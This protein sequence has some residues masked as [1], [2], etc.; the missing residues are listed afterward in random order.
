M[1]IERRQIGAVIETGPADWQIIQ[2]D[3][4]GQA[5]IS[6]AGSWVGDTPGNVEVRLLREES[7]APVAEDLDWQA[8]DRTLGDGSWRT[9]LRGVPAGG[10]YR[11]ETRYRPVK[12]IDPDWAPRGDM[13]H[14]IGVGDIWII[15]GQ[16]NAAGY[17]RG[18]VDD[19][20]ELGVHLFRNDEH[21]R[22]AAHPINES[23]NT[24]HWINREPSNPGHSFAL[25][26]GKR[27]RRELGYPIG[28]IQTAFGGSPLS[29]WNPSQKGRPVL[30]ENMLHLVGAAGGKVRGIVW[31][32][33]ETDALSPGSAAS[34]EE[35]FANAVA[36]WRE[37]LSE[38]DLPVVTVQLNRV[39]EPSDS[40]ADR[41]WSLVREAQRHAAATVPGVV[42]VSSQDLPLSDPVHISPQGNITLGN[43]LASASLGAV[44]GRSVNWRAPEVV[45]ANLAAN[46]RRVELRFEHVA[47]CLGAGT[48][49]AAGFR[50]EDAAGT[51]PIAKVEF[52]SAARI[53]LALQRE[54]GD[55]VVVHAG[56]GANPSPVPTDSARAMP[57]LAF[58]TPVV[59]G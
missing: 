7:G 29:A 32:Q 54:A 10:L 50:V 35:R 59:S 12:Q 28:L 31:Y 40:E 44:Y 8:A 58:S 23:T 25:Q 48:D 39:C 5:A 36:A 18:A 15:A 46:R 1:T 6:L 33:G 43:R 17:G 13:R 51:V 22:L 9:E 30:F 56:Y 21:W 53:E 34:Y 19:P 27:L 47:G 2:Q 14:F 37:A 41:R 16:S 24:R 52:P 55:D 38:P 20:P 42:V 26:L 57:I 3:A 4:D 45:S 11:I 49:Q